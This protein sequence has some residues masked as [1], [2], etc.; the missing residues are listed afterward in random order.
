MPYIIRDASREDCKDSV[1]TLNCFEFYG[2]CYLHNA[3]DGEDLRV[4]GNRQGMLLSDPNCV[5]DIAIV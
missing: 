5:E 4:P 3:M 1:E 2:E